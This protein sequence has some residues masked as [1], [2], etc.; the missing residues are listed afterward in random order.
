MAEGLPLPWPFPWSTRAEQLR[1][2]IHP[3]RAKA[4]PPGRAHDQ[5][6]PLE[7]IRAAAENALAEF[8]KI[9]PP[10]RSA[11]L[12]VVRGLSK[13]A[14]P[15]GERTG[16]LYG[17]EFLYVL[18][19]GLGALVGA[20]FS[21]TNLGNGDPKFPDLSE[22]T[23][24]SIPDRDD[25]S[26]IFPRVSGSL[27]VGLQPGTPEAD[28]RRVLEE[29]GVKDIEY[30]DFL[31]IVRCVPFDEEAVA[32]H[33]QDTVDFVKYVSW[34]TVVRLVDFSPGWQVSRVL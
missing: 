10:T 30:L 27:I 4:E 17:P 23:L 22:F 21:W 26:L 7:A 15:D 2:S 31:A 9:L 16:V 20:A 14:T 11:E 29:A 12:Y 28:V 33:L 6:A 24:R 19:V 32:K 25:G 5:F 13:Y 34:N 3:I 18:D 8:G 1:A